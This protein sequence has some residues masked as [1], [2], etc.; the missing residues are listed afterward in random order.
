MIHEK[1][2]YILFFN[3]QFIKNQNVFFHAMGEVLLIFGCDLR[4]KMADLVA[5]LYLISDQ[6]KE[7]TLMDTVSL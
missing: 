4:I 2:K 6:L 7:Y 3:H 5:I 1:G